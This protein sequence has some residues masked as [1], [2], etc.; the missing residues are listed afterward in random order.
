[1]V[2]RDS[3]IDDYSMVEIAGN[4]LVWKHIQEENALVASIPSV[5]KD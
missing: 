3:Y 2:Y 1:M 5:P 4:R